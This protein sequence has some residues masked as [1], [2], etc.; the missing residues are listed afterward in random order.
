[1]LYRLVGENAVLDCTAA[2]PDWDNEDIA[3]WLIQE[4]E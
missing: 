3:D 4:Y 2:H 1:M